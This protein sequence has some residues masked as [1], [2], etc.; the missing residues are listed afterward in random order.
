MAKGTVER[1]CL[2]GHNKADGCCSAS[3]LRWYPR[4]EHPTPDGDGRRRFDYLGGYPTKAAAQSALDQACRRR[5]DDLAADLSRATRR[6][7]AVASGP[8]AAHPTP[9]VNQLLDHWLAHLHTKGAIRLRTLGRYRQLLEHHLRPYLGTLSLSALSTL[10]IQRLYDHLAHQGR[11]D[12]KPGGLHPRTIRELHHCLHQ[13]VAYARRWHH[14][15]ANPADDAEPPALPTQAISSLT[16]EQVGRLL[17]A[18]QQD[19]RPWLRAFV[20][21]AAATG[22]RTGELCGLE[23]PDLDLEAGTIRFRQALSSVDQQ[24]ATGQ[25]RPGGRRGKLLV[26]GPLKTPASQAVLHLPAFAVAALRDHHQQQQQPR[27]GTADGRCARLRL[28]HVQPGEPPR[29]VELDL[30]LR[31]QW[32]TALRPNHASRAFRALAEATGIAAHPHLLRH[33]LASALAAAKEPAS[34][35]AEQLRRRRRHAGQQDLHPPASPDRTPAGQ[36]HPGG[37]RPGSNAGE[38]RR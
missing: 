8:A 25:P 21:L 4:I 3:C 36:A 5:H 27:T 11:K 14:L 29:P 13:A 18:A 20:V 38:D 34:V 10:Q 17:A 12:G 28:L 6:T 32:G 7:R 16:P 30:V 26:V 15:P 35:I 37:L 1:K 23:W 19:P 2:K 33:S 9:T 31:T 24:L 22:A